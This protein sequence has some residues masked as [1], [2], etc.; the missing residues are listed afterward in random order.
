[1]LLG[2]LATA[3]EEPGNRG[4]PLSQR[5]IGRAALPGGVDHKDPLE[6]VLDSATVFQGGSEAERFRQPAHVGRQPEAPFRAIVRETNRAFP[7]GH[8][9]LERTSPVLLRL[10][11]AE[12]VAG[13]RE[14]PGRLEIRVGPLRPEVGRARCA[15]QILAMAVQRV[16]ITVDVSLCGDRCNDETCPPERDAQ[17]ALHVAMIGTSFIRRSSTTRR[18]FRWCPR[19]PPIGCDSTRSSYKRNSRFR[20]KSPKRSRRFV[21]MPS[22]RV[23]CPEASFISTCRATTSRKPSCPTTTCQSLPI[24]VMPRSTSSKTHGPT[25]PMPHTTI[26]SQRP[27]IFA[28]RPIEIP[29]SHWP[30]T[31]RVRSL[32]R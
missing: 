20:Q 8:A 19:K 6:L 9:T 16:R 32:E 27:R 22:S 12:P 5:G 18:S 15:R 24:P 25:L 3:A 26:S 10:M 21:T 28:R 11:R 2:F 14:L 31:K 30:S 17:A 29:Q 23:G 4:V 13:S 1:M 7:G